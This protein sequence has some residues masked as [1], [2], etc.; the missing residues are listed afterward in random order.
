MQH[1]LFHQ[2]FVAQSDQLRQVR[3]WVRDT[4]MSCGMSEEQACRVV[5]GVNEACMNIITHAYRDCS[6]DIELD[7][8]QDQADLIF[9]LTDFAS[10]M[11]CSRIKSRDLSDIRPGG[12]GVHFIQEVMDEVSYLPGSN[13]SGNVVIMK[14]RIKVQGAG[15]GM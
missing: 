13:D 9:Q 6:G 2:R 12:L 8:L 7:I 5:I 3:E 4:A 14:V 10:T 11:D 15:H 1:H